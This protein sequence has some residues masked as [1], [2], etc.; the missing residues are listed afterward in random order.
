MHCVHVECTGGVHGVRGAAGR[1][2]GVCLPRGGAAGP[3]LPAAAAY[4]QCC[5]RSH[6]ARPHRVTGSFT[7]ATPRRHNM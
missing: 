3:A 4:G 5:G 7:I 6:R 1:G 2:V